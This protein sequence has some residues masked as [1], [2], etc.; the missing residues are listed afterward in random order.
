MFIRYELLWTSINWKAMFLFSGLVVYILLLL[1]SRAL[2]KVLLK[3]F[4]SKTLPWMKKKCKLR[5]INW[6]TSARGEKMNNFTHMPKATVAISTRSSLS[7]VQNCV[8]IDFLL[9]SPVMLVNIF[10][11]LWFPSF[12][13]K[14]RKSLHSHSAENKTQLLW[15]LSSHCY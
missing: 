8:M 12:C 4:L 2:L 7:K 13:K 14:I 15:R 11:R 1:P 6:L 5:S 9:I 3:L 10:T